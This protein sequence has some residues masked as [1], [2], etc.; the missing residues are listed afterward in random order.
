MLKESVKFNEPA[1]LGDQDSIEDENNN[2]IFNLKVTLFR[3]HSVIIMLIRCFRSALFVCL[4]G[5]YIQ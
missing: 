2:E 5:C 1:P 3:L 4:F